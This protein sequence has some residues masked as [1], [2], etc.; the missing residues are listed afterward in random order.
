MLREIINENPLSADYL[1]VGKNLDKIINK[2]TNNNLNV[3]VIEHKHEEKLLYKDNTH[4]YIK[5]GLTPS[6][7]KRLD[8]YQLDCIIIQHI[9]SL[10]I[11]FD[12]F[13]KTLKPLFHQHT[14]CYIAIADVDEIY[15]I[16][17]KGTLVANGYKVIQEEKIL[18]VKLKS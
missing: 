17:L 9:Q 14:N 13:A 2:L 11:N 7:V 5:T 18:R 1:V 3:F 6:H 15:A 10:I 12:D 16:N 8:K 4:I